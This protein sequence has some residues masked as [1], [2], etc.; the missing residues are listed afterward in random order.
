MS[1]IDTKAPESITVRRI[2]QAELA[3]WHSRMLR[4]GGSPD[5]RTVVIQ[6]GGDR[7]SCCTMG[8]VVALD[9]DGP[10]VAVASMAPDGEQGCGVPTVVGW[11]WRPGREAEG[12]AVFGAA[13]AHLAASRE[14]DVRVRFDATSRAEYETAERSACRR[15]LDLHEWNMP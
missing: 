14:G 7:L 10:P 9:G 8:A 3:D 15:L 13:V 4:A 11:W 2:G 6:F 1:R 5:A 12:L